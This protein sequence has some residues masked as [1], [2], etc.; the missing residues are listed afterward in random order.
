[1]YI[2]WKTQNVWVR[3]YFVFSVVFVVG[4]T[5]TS[6]TNTSSPFS[7]H[8]IVGFTHAVLHTAF[9]NT[10]WH[11]FKFTFIVSLYAPQCALSTLFFITN[12]ELNILW[13]TLSKLESS[14]LYGR[15]QPIFFSK[16]SLY[17]THYLFVFIAVTEPQLELLSWE[18]HI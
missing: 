12:R 5:T 15:S 1:M 7:L 3:I 6:T 8:T 17:S 9:F 10:T 4:L 13:Q 2:A 11:T 14:N 16:L 18:M